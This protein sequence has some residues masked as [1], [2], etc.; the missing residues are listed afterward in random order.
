MFSLRKIIWTTLFMQQIS[1]KTNIKENTNKG[2]Q[3]SQ[4]L[5]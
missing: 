3:L 4:E 2:S 1:M 5:M